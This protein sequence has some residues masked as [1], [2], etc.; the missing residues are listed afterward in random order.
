[1]SIIEVFKPTFDNFQETP[2]VIWRENNGPI[3]IAVNILDQYRKW[4]ASQ[5]L[6]LA[7]KPEPEP[8]FWES[9]GPAICRALEHCGAMALIIE[10]ASDRK[11]K[12]R[13]FRKSQKEHH[14][15]DWYCISSVYAEGNSGSTAT[16]VRVTM[17]T[18]EDI[19][20]T[21]SPV[22][23]KEWLKPKPASPDGVEI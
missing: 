4:K 17:P 14:S 5:A 1:M 13:W 18:D 21:F 2:I 11:V 9:H 20:F 19:D 12:Y 6:P 15:G 3:R 10:G 22:M 16:H 8:F 7:R 23:M